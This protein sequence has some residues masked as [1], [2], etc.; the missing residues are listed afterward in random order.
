MCNELASVTRKMCEW[1]LV[2]N[3]GLVRQIHAGD[4]GA[5]AELFRRMAPA[6]V[7]MG[8]VI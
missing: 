4:R 6:F 8:C 5:E 1:K 3:A 7:F 2:D